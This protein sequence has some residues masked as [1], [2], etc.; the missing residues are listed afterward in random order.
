MALRASGKPGKKAGSATKDLGCSIEFFKEYIASKFE[1]WMTWEN[2][3][4][5]TWHLDHIIPLASFDLTD[6]EQ[7]KRAAHYTN[8]QPLKAEDNR[9]KR[10]RIL[11]GTILDL[12]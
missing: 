5:D 3:G 9:N 6:R 7:F 8:H 12:L 10:D 11:E 2:R 1:P 4:I